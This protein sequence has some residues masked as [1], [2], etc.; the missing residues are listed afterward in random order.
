MD[1]KKEGE[2]EEKRYAEQVLRFKEQINQISNI[3]KDIERQIAATNNLTESC[4]KAY[5]QDTM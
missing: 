5:V 3:E 2:M 4:F 1:K